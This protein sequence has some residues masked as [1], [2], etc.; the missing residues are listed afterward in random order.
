MT[1]TCGI[2]PTGIVTMAMKVLHNT[3]NMCTLDLPDMNALIPWSYI[4][5]KSLMLKLQPRDQSIRIRQITNAYV[6]IIQRIF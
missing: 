2:Q 4:S 6:K 3:C 5:G 1:I